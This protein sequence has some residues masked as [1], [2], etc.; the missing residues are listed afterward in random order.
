MDAIRILTTNGPTGGNLNDVKKL[1]TVI[2]SAD[3]VAA[4]AFATTLFDMKPADVDYIKL[5]DEMGLGTMDLK[6]VRI[7]EVSV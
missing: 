2:A 6:I 1:D 3:V 4:D 7:E 5:G